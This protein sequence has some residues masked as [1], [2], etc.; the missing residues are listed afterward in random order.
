MKENVVC[1]HKNFKECFTC[2]L[3]MDRAQN[4][5]ENSYFYC[6]C[7][8]R[9]MQWHFR[10]RNCHIDLN[11]NLHHAKYKE[12]Q[13]GNNYFL[14]RQICPF[15][16]ATVES[17]RLEKLKLLQNSLYEQHLLIMGLTQSPCSSYQHQWVFNQV[18]IQLHLCLCNTFFHVKIK[19][20]FGVFFFNML[21]TPMFLF[22]SHE[23]P[24]AVLLI[25]NYIWEL[26]L[27]VNCWS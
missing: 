9:P 16:F 15:S 8:A 17:I 3:K 6:S 27:N 25:Q 14:T 24:N 10:D 12:M 19:I 22:V 1:R 23:W 7:C 20:G 26:W 21:G 11:K 18:W 4:D 13:G 2:F 5:W